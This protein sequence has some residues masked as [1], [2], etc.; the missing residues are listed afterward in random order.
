MARTETPNHHGSHRRLIW[1]ADGSPASSSKVD[2]IIVPTARPV[3]Y[4]KEAASAAVW[5]GCPL[6]TLHSKKWTSA[7]AAARYLPKDVDLIAIDVP[8][9]APLRLPD[10]ETSRLLDPTPFKRRIDLS[11]KRNLALMLSHMLG[12]ERVVFIDDDIQVPDPGDLSRAVGLLDIHTA[13]GLG[14][15]GFP[16]NSVVCH[17]FRDVGG[18]QETFIGG[19]ALAVE[20][21]RNRSF[22]P[23]IYNDDWFYVLD[24]GK[25]LQSVA[26]VG[27][28]IQSPYDPYRPERARNEEFGDVLAE[29]TFWLLDQGK[30]ASD[31]DLAHWQ[32][33]LERRQRFIWD[34]LS[35]VERKPDIEAA[36][37]GR[38]IEAL[39]ASL[40]RRALIDPELC[41]AYLR[42]WVSDQERWQRHI[43]GVRQQPKLGRE[44]ALKSLGRKGGTPLTW[45]T[46]QGSS[47]GG[48]A[49]AVGGRRSLATPSKGWREPLPGELERVLLACE[50][51]LGGCPASCRLSNKSSTLVPMSSGVAERVRGNQAT[52]PTTPR[53]RTWTLTPGEEAAAIAELKQAA[54]GWA[55]LLAEC[56]GLA[57]GYGEHH[58]DAARY[59]QIA[60]LCIAAGVEETLVEAWV[61]VGRQ[62]ASTAAAITHKTCV[63]WNS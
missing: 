45:Y 22:F 58:L 39:K 34:I 48:G 60:E 57:A 11:G 31:G 43:Q 2:A 55:A 56:A 59:R 42:A 51:E 3:A 62:R 12:W 46:R 19:G 36:L 50:V 44:W 53:A 17:A 40:G 6:V 1:S 30:T 32:E 49:S 29:G 9:S 28:V 63:L 13:V 35:M 54:T 23:D 61:E 14:I 10:F 41:V 8:E 18:K 25:R 47:A 5:L 27:E 4:L 15:G 24:A 38:M 33:F 20:V 16:D 37:R 7:Q 26:T 21:K 52:G